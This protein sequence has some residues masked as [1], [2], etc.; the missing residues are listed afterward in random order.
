MKHRAL[1]CERGSYK[2][3]APLSRFNRALN[4]QA[5]I[6]QCNRRP[7]H[8]QFGGQL[9]GGRQ[10]RIERHCALQNGAAQHALDALLQRFGGITLGK[11]GLPQL[12]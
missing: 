10:R 4:L 2:K 5:L 7:R 9:A 11:P 12:A 3:T 1:L 6:R 8:T